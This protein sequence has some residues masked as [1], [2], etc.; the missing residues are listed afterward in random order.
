MKQNWKMIG[1]LAVLLAGVSWTCLGAGASALPA[2]VQEAA[3]YGC[4][5]VMDW[6]HGNLVGTSTNATIAFTNTFTG[7]VSVR[8]EGLILDTPFDS[9]SVTNPLVGL[10]VSVGTTS[11]TTKW[12]NGLEIAYDATPTTYS[13]FGT[14]Y[15]V[16]IVSTPYLTNTAVITSTPTLQTVTP[17]NL[18]AGEEVFSAILVTNLTVAS[19]GTVSIAGAVSSVGTVT[20]PWV[21]A[22][23][24]NVSIVTT[25]AMTGPTMTHTALDAGR[26]RTF[27]KVLGPKY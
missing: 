8:F 9:R 24:G 1:M 2:T 18:V 26:L 19:E 23:T 4:T 15:S 20:S 16:S 3:K 12:L 14:D 22:Q 17:T 27:W 13:S 6:G 21:N 7:P 5:H 11:S 10:A 25:F